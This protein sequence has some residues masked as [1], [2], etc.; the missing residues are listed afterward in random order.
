ML[1]KGAAGKTYYSSIF[2]LLMQ[3]KYF[4]DVYK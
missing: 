1:V 3:Y 4:V 2:E